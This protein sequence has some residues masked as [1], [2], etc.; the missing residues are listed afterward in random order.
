MVLIVS[1][2]RYSKALADDE[3]PPE[4]YKG[5]V[6]GEAAFVGLTDKYTLHAVRNYLSKRA[7]SIDPVSMNEHGTVH[8]LLH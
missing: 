7:M 3:L 1:V 5:M 2:N 8:G 6:D 4:N